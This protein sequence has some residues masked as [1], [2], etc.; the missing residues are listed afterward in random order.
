MAG[1]AGEDLEEAGFERHVRGCPFG[2]GGAAACVRVACGS[3][4]A[5]AGRAAVAG[6]RIGP[7]QRTA[8]GRGAARSVGT[9]GGSPHTRPFPKPGRAPGPW[10]GSFAP[11]GH[12]QPGEPWAY[13]TGRVGSS[14][15]REPHA[16]WPA[17][18]AAARVRAGR[19]ARSRR[20]GGA[21]VGGTDRKTR[22]RAEAAEPCR[23]L[24]RADTHP[25]CR[26]TYGHSAPW[27]GAAAPSAEGTTRQTGSTPTS[28]VHRRRGPG[29][30][31]APWTGA[32]LRRRKSPE[33][34]RRSPAAWF[35]QAADRTADPRRGLAPWAG[36]RPLGDG[37]TGPAAAGRGPG[38]RGRPW[39]GVGGPPPGPQI[40]AVPADRTAAPRTAVS[41]RPRAGSEDQRRAGAADAGPAGFPACR[42]RGAAPP[43]TCPTPRGPA[44]VPRPSPLPSSGRPVPPR[45]AAAAVPCSTGGG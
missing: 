24:V 40:P 13:G 39:P 8:G 19:R 36:H 18:S 12:R 33:N 11:P 35:G 14:T 45:S 43:P 27:P 26:P 1:G 7:R 30:R 29:P 42:K 25:H 4:G 16:G 21:S 5:A 28:A 17:A 10:G 37:T 31:L 23:G 44:P 20:R 2:W 6:L 38:V 9:G 22:G 15:G 41:R 32:P 3:R 34:G